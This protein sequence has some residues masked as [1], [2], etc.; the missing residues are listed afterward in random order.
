M[1][2]IDYQKLYALQDEVLEFVN[3][4]VNDFYLTG[5]TALN[6]FLFKENTR[7]SDDLD[8]F[9]SSSTDLS[10]SPQEQIKEIITLLKNN[11]DTKIESSYDDFSRII[12]S[13]DETKLQVDFIN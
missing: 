2:K 11:F 12:I 7:H 6:R 10:S 8:F 3:S 1:E 13:K 4:K 9:I 5:G